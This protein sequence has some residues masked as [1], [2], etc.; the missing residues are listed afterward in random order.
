MLTPEYLAGVAD[1]LLDTY[2]ELQTRIQRDIA[3]RIGKADYTIT[4]T[5]KWQITKLQETGESLAAIQQYIA[6]TLN[7]SEKQVK[8]LFQAA[9]VKSMKTDIETQ[10]AAIKAGKLPKDSVPLAASPAF[11]QIMTANLLRTNNTLRQLTR[12]MAQDA[13]GQL[14]A[15][16]DQAQLMVQSGAFTQEQA[17]AEAVKKFAADGVS[18][19]DYATGAR[20]SVEAGVRRAVVTGVNQATAEVS[21]SNAGELDT[22]LVEVTS[23]ADA[24]PEHA[25]WQGGIYSL[26]GNS[27]KCRKLSEATGYGTVSGL[28]GANCRHSFYAYIEGV[29]ERVPREKYDPD[30]YEAEQEQRYNERMIRHWKRRA[31]TLEAGGVENTK[32]LMKVRQWQN[33]L[34]QHIE[35]TGLARIS[36]REHVPGF[37]K[38]LAQK[39]VQAQKR[40]A[41]I[42]SGSFIQSCIKQK[43]IGE[44]QNWAKTTLGISRVNYTGQ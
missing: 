16:L 40:S 30:T 20:I 44:A 23:H 41:Q 33:R 6:S 36:A 26:S 27:K 29:S 43:T 35:D 13:S 5:A 31:A 15:Y 10:Q 32:E 2:S 19:F 3:R 18:Y 25:V 22:D 21:V 9:G 17:I 37:G 14:N 11:T 1:P 42:K 28:C 39:A 24:R 12:T 7:L 34:K 38:S 4:D 8:T